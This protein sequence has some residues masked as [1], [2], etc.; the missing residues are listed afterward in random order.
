LSAPNCRWIAESLDADAYSNANELVF[1]NN[2]ANVVLP[3]SRPLGQ[4][5][6]TTMFESVNISG[7]SYQSGANIQTSAAVPEPST[8]AMMILGFA[9]VGFMA[10]RRK[11]KPSLMGA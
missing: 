7:T 2:N 8:W 11:A 9:G 5:T 1:E 10:Y 6:D 3:F 4:P